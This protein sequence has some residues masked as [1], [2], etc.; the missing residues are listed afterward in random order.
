M[1]SQLKPLSSYTPSIIR[2]FKLLQIDRKNTFYNIYG[3]SSYRD[4][5]YPSDIDLFE[6][7]RVLGTLEESI[8]F[9]V[10]NIQRVVSQIIKRKN[11][12]FC[13]LKCGLDKRYDIEIG[14]SAN[15]IFHM[16][17]GLTKLLEQM[18]DLFIEDEYDI[19]M[20]ICHKKEKKQIDF[21]TMKQVL[22]KHYIVR[23]TAKEVL[24]GIKELPFN[25]GQYSLKDAVNNISP[26]NIEILAIV[27]D[28]YTD[29][30]TYLVL[31]YDP[32][33]DEPKVVN[34]PQD[35][36]T[37]LDEYI[38]QQLKQQIEKLYYSK[39]EFNPVK[40]AKRYLNYG[41][42]NQKN[43]IVNSILPLLNSWVGFTY[44]I[45]TELSTLIKVNKLVPIINKTIFNNQLQN[46]KY[47]LSNVKEIDIQTLETL[48]EEIDNICDGVLNKEE[49]NELL[50]HIKSMLIDII[51]PSTIKWLEDISLAPPPDNLL[52]KNRLFETKP[53]PQQ[54]KKITLK[55][56]QIERVEE[57]EEHPA[58]EQSKKK[59][60]IIDFAE[61]LGPKSYRC[62]ICEN[63]KGQRQ[64]FYK[65]FTRF[66]RQQLEQL[67]ASG[68]GGSVFSE[69]GRYLKGF[70][71]AIKGIRTN[72]KPSVR[73]LLKKYGDKS[74]KNI[75]ICRKPLGKT[76]NDVLN[77]LNKL[78]GK[79]AQH[80]KLF[81]LFALAKLNDDTMIRIEKNEDINLVEYK[82]SILPTDCISVQLPSKLTINEM[83]E[84][85]L[86]KVGMKDFFEYNAFSTNCQ[87][88]IYNF[89][90]SNQVPVSEELKKFIL[91]DVKNLTPEWG[92]KLAHFLTSLKNKINIVVQGE[93]AGT[94]LEWRDIPI[95]DLIN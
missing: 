17:Q 19:L 1:S 41:Y 82:D 76:Y 33:D 49:I 62:K 61:K 18:K 25:G 14:Y 59:M 77:I 31:V 47:R 85:T 73:E 4:A 24:E 71:M 7:V 94:N 30:S 56:I 63:Y 92:Q 84:N 48:N 67:L 86:K 35:S 39:L 52:P 75:I 60:D 13:E 5:L 27:N 57:Q 81:H 22:R 93:G 69:I 72:F 95:D 29:V 50:N 40:L 23:W 15:D 10:E 64:G 42:Y 44:N 83:L 28:K 16:T 65:H 46:I 70:L 9:F 20:T 66:H 58:P 45:V 43:A 36:L 78:S 3:S 88:F 54:K 38:N 37:N 79:E 53:S 21:E 12:Y 11:H 8:N 80:D 26:I 91:Q 55:P 89:L 32:P 74:I 34:L 87:H 6:K 2:E 90:L 68:L 51:N